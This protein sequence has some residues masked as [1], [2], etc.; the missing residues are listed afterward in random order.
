MSDET[1]YYDYPSEPIGRGAVNVTP[2]GRCADMRRLWSKVTSLFRRQ[3]SLDFSKGVRGA[4]VVEDPLRTWVDDF[5]NRIVSVHLESIKC[6]SEGCAIHHPSNHAMSG[7]KRLWRY[8]VRLMER[9]CPHGVGHPDPDHLRFLASL[10]PRGKTLS[11]SQGVHGCD[12]C[13]K[14]EPA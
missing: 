8:D 9:I 3:K 5:G 6:H 10:G 4:V 1:L 2:S 13:C 11:E 7:F 12:G 14:G